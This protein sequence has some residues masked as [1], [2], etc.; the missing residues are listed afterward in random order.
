MEYIVVA[1]AVPALAVVVHAGLP[2][3]VA[4][5]AFPV[6]LLAFLVRLLV[7]VFVTRGGVIE[8]GGDNLGYEARAMEIVAAW[9]REGLHFVTGEENPSLVGV[10]LPCHIFAV[11]M[12]LCGGPAS[13]ACTAVVALVACALCVVMYRFARQLGADERAAFLLLVIMAFLPSFL[14][15]TSDMYKDGFNAFLVVAALHAGVSI[16]RRFE[17]RRA[18][19]LGSLLWALWYVRP[20]MVFMLAIP[21]ALS[22]LGVERGVSPRR[23]LAFGALLAGAA[24]LFAG[25]VGGPVETMMHQLDI[26]Q[27][28]AVREANGDGGSGV[29][30][31][32]GGNAWNAL[33]PKLVYTLFSP[34]PWS[35]GSLALQLGKIDVLI[36][37]FLLYAAVRGSRILWR[38]DRRVLLILLLFIVPSTVAYATTVANIGLIFRQRMPIVMVVGLLAAVLWSR[39]SGGGWKSNSPA[40]IESNRI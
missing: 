19:V 1:A 21:L 18:L 4:R 31:N 38:T 11:V 25:V 15:H 39:N 5:R 34:F 33:G 23:L 14:L 32:D 7:H 27:S 35:S 28:D 12:Y 26:G 8:Y 3:A 17:T 36:W 10:A 16:A 29:F 30:F 22:L 20:Y 24:S 40:K 37:Y 13:L 2:G 9:K 6:L